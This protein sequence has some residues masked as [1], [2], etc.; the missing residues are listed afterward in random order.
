MDFLGFEDSY[1]ELGDESFELTVDQGM[2]ESKISFYD[3]I[4]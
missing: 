4:C 3:T 2:Y 1:F